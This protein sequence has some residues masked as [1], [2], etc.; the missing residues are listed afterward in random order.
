MNA[1]I[2]VDPE[3]LYRSPAA[4]Y[5]FLITVVITLLRITAAQKNFLYIAPE[6]IT[7]FA[8][9]STE[10]IVD[11]HSLNSSSGFYYLTKFDI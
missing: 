3:S 6:N 11:P 8:E 2:Y 9:V 4:F 10:S 5:E 1:L 7:F